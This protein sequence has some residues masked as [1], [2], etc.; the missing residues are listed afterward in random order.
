MLLV[1]GVEPDSGP[2]FTTSKE[3]HVADRTNNATDSGNVIDTANGTAINSQQQF[4]RLFAAVN[5][6]TATVCEVGDKVEHF[7]HSQNEKGSRI[8]QRLGIMENAINTRI[9]HVEENQNV[10]RIGMDAMGYAFTNKLD[11]FGLNKNLFGTK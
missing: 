8:N 5:Q 3:N 7:E 4:D 11:S 2:T 6:F 9:T 1:A 10:L